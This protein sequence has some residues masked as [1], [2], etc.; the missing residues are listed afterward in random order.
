MKIKKVGKN[1]QISIGKE[2]AEKQV[3]I[4]KLENGFVLIKQGDFIPRNEKWLY[5]E[6]N[7]KRIKESLEWVHK[8]KRKENFREI[9]VRINSND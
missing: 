2:Y 7:I 3:Q 8:N 1:G 5:K 9:E 6:D 4:C